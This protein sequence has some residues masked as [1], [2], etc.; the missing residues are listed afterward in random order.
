MC[1]AAGALMGAQQPPLEQGRDEMNARQQLVRRLGVLGQVRNPVPV[2]VRLHAVV[3][4][5]AIRVHLTARLDDVVDESLEALRRRVRHAAQPNPAEPLPNI[6]GSDDNQGFFLGSAATDAI[7]EA[8]DVRLVHFDVAGEPVPAGPHHRPSQFV[9]PGPGRL[10]AAQAQH[11]LQR[12]RARPGLLTGDGP[13]RSKPD[14]ER[15]AGVLEDRPSRDGRLAATGGTLEQ[16][17][18]QPARPSAGHT[19]GSGIRLASAAEPS[20]PDTPPRTRTARRTR[21][22]SWG[23]PPRGPYATYWGYL[24]Q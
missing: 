1:G 20:R 19:P 13:H 22:D 4:R 24:S 9:Q 7:L 21:P 14:G 18:A 17:A 5:P 8:P 3:A 15:A 10:V 12:Q 11:L 23:N 2:A 6:L 16:P